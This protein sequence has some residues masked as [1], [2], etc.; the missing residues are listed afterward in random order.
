[1][2]LQEDFWESIGVPI[3]DVLDIEIK[4][5]DKTGKRLSKKLSKISGNFEPFVKQYY[6]VNGESFSDVVT[7]IYKTS[8]D[9]FRDLYAIAIF[10][11]KGINL[12]IIRDVAKRELS[13]K[14]AE[15]IDEE[16]MDALSLLLPLFKHKP[17]TLKEIYYENLF[18]CKPTKKFLC[19]PL[20]TPLLF[21]KIDSKKIDDI[22]QS[23]ERSR[24]ADLRRPIKLWWFDSNS[25]KG[26]IVFRRQ[27]NASSELKLVEKNFFAKTG[28]EKIFIFRDGGNTLEMFSSREPL[29]TV[30]V[31]E[32]IVEKLTGQK[33][34]YEKAP[35]RYPVAKVN[36]F[37]Q[38]LLTIE[39][40]SVHVLGMRAKNAPLAKSPILELESFETIIPAI[41]ELQDKG[42][43]LT[44][45]CENILNLR[46]KFEGRPYNLKIVVDGE[47]I[48]IFVD[49]RN[50]REEEK[51]KLLDFLDKQIG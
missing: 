25:G 27:K 3:K 47:E 6:N 2:S 26:R 20:S 32:F 4:F 8:I 16:G 11:D 33:I 22:L 9:D 41:K 15:N 18:E 23:F 50:I 30:R 35:T 7:K 42:V 5:G 38:K 19:E 44:E 21:D 13:G 43:M 39:N 49:N 17:D 14:L 31:A 29:R 51:Q 10:A 46:I 12:N 28:D 45:H 1:M 48:E 40:D 34:K 36:N 37:L 24:R